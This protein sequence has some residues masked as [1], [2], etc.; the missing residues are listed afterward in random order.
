MVR[1]LAT[2]PYLPDIGSLTCADMEV[3]GVVR[4]GA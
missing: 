1:D 4:P 3:C 2:D